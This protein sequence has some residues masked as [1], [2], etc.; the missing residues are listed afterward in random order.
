M[1]TAREKRFCS[2]KLTYRTYSPD[3][4]PAQ[5]KEGFDAWLAKQCATTKNKTIAVRVK[6]L[7]AKSARWARTCSV[8]ATLLPWYCVYLAEQSVLNW[9][10]GV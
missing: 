7:E 5:T 4:R 6:K 9:C 1:S 10:P 3:A 8:T 2:Y